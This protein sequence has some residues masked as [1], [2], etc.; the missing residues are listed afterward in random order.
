M[1]SVFKGSQVFR[2]FGHALLHGS[3][4]NFRKA[5]LRHRSFNSLGSMQ[6]GLEI[7]GG[8]FE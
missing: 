2:I 5:S 8:A 4:D 7:Y 6:G 3:V 1:R